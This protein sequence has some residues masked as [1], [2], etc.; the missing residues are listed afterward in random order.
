MAT[1]ATEPDSELCR[2]LFHYVFAPSTFYDM[3][4]AFG[5]DF[6]Q[7]IHVTYDLCSAKCGS[8]IYFYNWGQA[9]TILMTWSFPILSLAVTASYVSNDSS[10]TLWASARWF[11]SPLS[12]LTQTFL[13]LQAGGKCASIVRL[14]MEHGVALEEG[15]DFDEIRDSFYLL[16][17]M[18]QFTVNEAISRLEADSLIRTALFSQKLK[19]DE[20]GGELD[21]VVE[22]KILASKI[23]RMRRKGVVQVLITMALFLIAFGISLENAFETGSSLRGLDFGIF[24]TWLPTLLVSGVI[25][26]NLT[27]TDSPQEELNR[28]VRLVHSA[29]LWQQRQASKKEII[30]EKVATTSI[31]PAASSQA[32]YSP[33]SITALAATATTRPT[34]RACT[35]FFYKFAGQGRLPFHTGSTSP[36]LT[37]LLA[38][39]SIPFTRSGWLNAST[40]SVLQRAG[41]AATNPAPPFSIFSCSFL[42]ASAL[43]VA[44]FGSSV[45]GTI[46][47][48]F[49]QPPVGMTCMS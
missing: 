33:T 34:G 26:I 29:L 8:K 41:A 16:G 25:D 42:I 15:S 38:L 14:A 20:E 46:V 43:A 39:P 6:N 28:F 1:T 47:Y 30:A 2:N 48:H 10:G 4:A 36:L 23:R 32:S 45:A 49:Y 24:A 13:S 5:T 37:T 35:N 44:I 11:G 21:L 18:N 9:S 27:S 22:R 12:A 3:L 19:R 17:A 31:H 7:T 40:K